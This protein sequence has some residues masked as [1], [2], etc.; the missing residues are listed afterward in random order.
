MGFLDFTRK[1]AVLSLL[2]K[3]KKNCFVSLYFKEN[4]VYLVDF[5]KKW[6]QCYV[7]ELRPLE[8]YMLSAYVSD[9]SYIIYDGQPS[10]GIIDFFV[11]NR[12][13]W[14]VVD[15]YTVE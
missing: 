11:Y 3:R 4:L 6:N 8:L 7:I 15:S 1:Q 2:R 9:S 14:K 5:G 13:K 12:R 10:S